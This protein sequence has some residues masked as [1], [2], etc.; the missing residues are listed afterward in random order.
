MCCRGSR[1]KQV[2]HLDNAVKIKRSAVYAAGI[3]K[4][5]VLQMKNAVKDTE[6]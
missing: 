2:L 4:K 3:T 1:K 5:Q 6:E